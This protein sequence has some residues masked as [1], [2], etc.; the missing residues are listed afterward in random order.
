[1]D[2]TMPEISLLNWGR[3]LA[4]LA[5]TG[6]NYAES[7]F[8]LQR[9]EEVRKI[10]AELMAAVS[11]HTPDQLLELFRADRGYGTPKVDVRGM[12]FRGDELLLVREK[13]DG[14]WTPPGGWVDVGETP[15]EAVE[16]E[17]REESGYLAKAGKLIGV[18]ER[19][20]RGHTPLAFAVIK[21]F[22]QCELTGGAAMPSNE[23]TEVGFFHRDALPPLSLARVVPYEIERAYAHRESPSLPTEL[24]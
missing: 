24:D 17:V 2:K 5:Q 9:Y 20:R 22:I 23:T 1:M 16:K 21:L 14:G 6:T 10:A 18:Y 3:R 19:D 4:A 12:V 11:V 7:P 8:D 13:D 15:T